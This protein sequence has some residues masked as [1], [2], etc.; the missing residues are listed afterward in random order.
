MKVTGQKLF[1][2]QVLR[3]Q[4]KY[5]WTLALSLEAHLIKQEHLE[6]F[7]IHVDACPSRI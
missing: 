3:D 2:E 1:L 6:P 4:K 7:E 5:V